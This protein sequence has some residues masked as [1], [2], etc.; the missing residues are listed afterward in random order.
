MSN[1]GNYAQS[2]PV[3]DCQ[4]KTFDTVMKLINLGKEYAFVKKNEQYIGIISLDKILEDH[5]DSPVTD[6]IEPLFIVKADDHKHKATTLMSENKV[7]HIAVANQ[8]GELI[9]IASAKKVLERS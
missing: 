3:I 9:G 7:E 8:V 4:L 2:A 5:S 1:I 6:F